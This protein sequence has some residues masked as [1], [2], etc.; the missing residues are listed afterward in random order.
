MLK[1]FVY[2]NL[3]NVHNVYSSV[4]IDKI[5]EPKKLIVDFYPSVL[6]FVLGAQKKRLIET[7][8]W[9]THNICFT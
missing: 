9:S 8:L 3:R 2:L 6:T 5:F 4:Q 7:V 1:I